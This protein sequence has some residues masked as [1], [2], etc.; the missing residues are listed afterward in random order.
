MNRLFVRNFIFGT[1][2]YLVLVASEK[3]CLKFC[4]RKDMYKYWLFYVFQNMTVLVSSDEI[5]TT[6]DH[7]LIL[8]GL[9]SSG[10]AAHS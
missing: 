3:L 9:T 7:D 2:V 1:T 8:L 4:S 6:A 5:S 10:S